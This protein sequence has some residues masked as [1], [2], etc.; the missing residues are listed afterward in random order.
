MIIYFSEIFF[1]FDVTLKIDLVKVVYYLK[2]SKKVF[3]LLHDKSFTPV[4][5]LLYFVAA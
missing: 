5:P 3:H 2:L 4:E 1:H